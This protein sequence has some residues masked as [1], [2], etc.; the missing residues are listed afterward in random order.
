MDTTDLTIFAL[1]YPSPEN[2]N[3]LV[4]FV[5]GCPFQCRWCPNPAI[6]SSGLSITTDIDRCIGCRECEYGC[7]EQALKF[8]GNR[9]VRTE[10]RC[11]L[12]MNC[13][14]I[15]PTLVHRATGYNYSLEHALEYLGQ[16]HEK[17]RQVVFAGGEPLLQYASLKFFLQKF[18]ELRIQRAIHTSGYAPSPLLLKIAEHAEIFYYDLKHMDPAK[19]V[20]LTGITNELILRN[21]Q[22]LSKTGIPVRIR[23]PLINNVNSDEGNIRKTGS[24]ISKLEGNPPVDI[25]PYTSCFLKGLKTNNNN[26]LQHTLYPSIE[27]LNNAKSILEGYDLHVTIVKPVSVF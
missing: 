6:R 8:I 11:H 20:I 2:A 25:H 12:C 17:V 5:K 27:S 21:L 16:K 26:K 3:R 22:I 14:E 4:F 1:T 15:C 9:L 10:S 19:H 18:G 7:Q 24:F 13:V 23:F